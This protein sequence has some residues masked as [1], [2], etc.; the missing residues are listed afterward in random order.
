[1]SDEEHCSAQDELC[2]WCLEGLRAGQNVVRL[3]IG[4]PFLY[5]R[6]GEEVLFFRK[7]GYEAT[8]IPGI[9][10]ALA[11]PM[12]GTK[13]TL[14]ID[15][16]PPTKLNM[17]ILARIPLT[18]RGIADHVVIHTGRGYK[19]APPILPPYQAHRT[20]VLLMATGRLSEL[21]LLLLENAYP[22]T[23]P[24]SVI[25]NATCAMQ[26]VT[27]ATVDTLP[28]VAGAVGVGP[29]AVIVIGD[30]V[31]VLDEEVDGA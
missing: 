11:A 15:H 14:P 28:A 30:V 5:G 23:C 29:P 7:H 2:V 1:M 24:V 16:I 17:H 22:S 3:K 27:R 31:G 19:G 13:L 18:H 12:A 8:I 4:D 9:S 21:R 6:G 10:S 26:R 20:T 25:E